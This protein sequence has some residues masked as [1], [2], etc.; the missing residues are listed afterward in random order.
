M[1]KTSRKSKTVQAVTEK[2][3]I[4]ERVE[5]LCALAELRLAAELIRDSKPSESEFD[6]MMAQHPGLR[7]VY[8]RL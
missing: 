2:S 7:D 4:A 5:R 3:D 1:A 8:T 6:E